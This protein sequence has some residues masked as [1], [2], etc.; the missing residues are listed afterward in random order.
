MRRRRER[1]T[2]HMANMMAMMT[3]AHATTIMIMSRICAGVMV[4]ASTGDAAKQ[5]SSMN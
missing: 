1:T 5:L 2:M 4:D 3:S